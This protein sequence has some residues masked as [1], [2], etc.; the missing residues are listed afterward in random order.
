MRPM[1]STRVVDNH[2]NYR[3]RR[4][5][6]HSLRPDHGQTAC[7]KHG[8]DVAAQNGDHRA[9]SGTQSHTVASRHIM[10]R[11]TTH[12][13]GRINLRSTCWRSCRNL[14]LESAGR[15]M[16]VG[17]TTAVGAAERRS[18][19][20]RVRG[21]S[22][23]TVFG[24]ICCCRVRPDLPRLAAD[25]SASVGLHMIEDDDATACQHPQST[26][27]SRGICSTY[28]DGARD[29]NAGTVS[30]QLRLVRPG[31]TLI[32]AGPKR[33]GFTLFGLHALGFAP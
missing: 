7:V 28:Y 29:P 3:V 16:S 24:S 10:V 2:A 18:L 21:T 32:M 23:E 4:L 13:M 6:P 26:A 12:W 5:D 8:R 14:A 33:R 27:I 1:R 31:A 25:G 17:K 11:R 30:S 22:R 19:A 20:D 9:G 15:S